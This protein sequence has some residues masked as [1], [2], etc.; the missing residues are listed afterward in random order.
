MKKIVTVTIGLAVAA[1]VAGAAQAASLP[2]LYNDYSSDTYVFG[3]SQKNCTGTRRT[4]FPGGSYSS[5]QS[6][7]SPESGYGKWQNGNIIRFSGNYCINLPSGTA[8]RTYN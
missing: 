4:V 1:I 8:I 7:K 2:K 6:F 3:Y 5:A